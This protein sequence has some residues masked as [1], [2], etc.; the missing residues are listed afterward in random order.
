MILKCAACGGDMEIAG[1]IPEN[2]TIKCPHCGE[3]VRIDRPHRLEVPTNPNMPRFVPDDGLPDQTSVRRRPDLHVRRPAPVTPAT[4]TPAMPP[5]QQNPRTAKKKNGGSGDWVIYA[6]LT[7]VVAGLGIYWMRKS[8]TALNEDL[9]V[10]AQGGS[11]VRLDIDAEQEKLRAE[12]RAREEAER[13]KRRA[14]K[15]KRDAE[16]ER[17]R[18]EMAEK[19]KREREVREIVSKAEMSFSG[20]TSVFASDFPAGK[21]PFD[22]AEDGVIVVAD[23]NYIGGRSL[24]R[25]TVEGKRLK[26]VQKVSQRDGS[27]DIN[28][29]DFM[30]MVTNKIVLAK[31]GAGP[32]WICGN[33]KS[34]EQIE[35]LD[36]SDAYSPLSLFMGGS[37]PVLNALH[38][39]PPVIKYRVTLRAKNGNGEIKIG[40]FEK[41]INLQTIRSKVRE[42]LTDRK[43]KSSGLGIK[44][45]SMKKIK[46][47]VVFYD[48]EKIVKGMTGVTKVPRSFTFFGT[49]RNHDNKAHVA[50]IVANARRKWESLREEAERQDRRELEIEVE[51]Q[52]RMDE[53]RRKVEVALRNSKPSED[54]VDNELRLYRLS[55]ERSRTKLLKK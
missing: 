35:A 11:S 22:F 9:D 31:L 29:D 15:A 19:A 16:R 40:V 27:A 5:P 44:P 18:Q 1:N 48:G 45:P 26:A 28:P 34:T 8:N 20:M 43:L 55:I 2:V 17:E 14:E 37:L 41:E 39:V 49:A 46:R 12:R 32:V 6:L 3:H 23:E 47:T 53:Y 42:Q 50:D 4:A 24:Y 38:V 30:R 25:L 36:A 21:R 51:N 33:A 52:R 54:E 13:E 10:S 7:V